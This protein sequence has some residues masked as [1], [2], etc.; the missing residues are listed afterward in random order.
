M[1][2]LITVCNV[3]EVA[4][5]LKDISPSEVQVENQQIAQNILDSFKQA[6]HEFKQPIPNKSSQIEYFEKH[7]K[8]LISTTQTVFDSI[9]GNIQQKILKKVK[10]KNLDEVDG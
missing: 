1:K 5:L 4:E 2:K 6:L 8:D 10:F 9:D 3:V 7:I